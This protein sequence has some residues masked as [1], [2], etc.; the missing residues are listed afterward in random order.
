MPQAAADILQGIRSPLNDSFRRFKV[1]NGSQR[2]PCTSQAWACAY[3]DMMQIC[4]SVTSCCNMPAASVLCTQCSDP[5]LETFAQE[6]ADGVKALSTPAPRDELGELAFP[7]AGAQQAMR[8]GAGGAAG[9]G[10]A[11]GAP[12]ALSTPERAAQGAFALQAHT[13]ALAPATATAALSLLDSC[14]RDVS[15][16]VERL[17]VIETLLG[18]ETSIAQRLERDARLEVRNLCLCTSTLNGCCLLRTIRS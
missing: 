10:G 4:E 7:N 18:A 15:G 8:A 3:F 5:N 17:T 6:L 1:W 13:G 16:L 11:A 9:V 12:A 14:M 2:A